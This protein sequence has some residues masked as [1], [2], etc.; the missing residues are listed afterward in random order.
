[1]RVFDANR[2]ATI[3]VYGTYN[4]PFWANIVEG[5]FDWTDF[6]PAYEEGLYDYS[7]ETVFYFGISTG[8]A[9]ADGFEGQVD[10]VRIVLNNGAVGAINFEP[11]PA[12][13]EDVYATDNCD[14]SVDV[15]FEQTIVPGDC[16]SNYTIYRTWTATDTCENSTSHTQVI[17]VIDTT[18]PTFNM[19]DSEITVSCGDEILIAAPVATDNC[20]I[21]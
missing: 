15:V 9:W 2:G 20:D 7:N 6:S 11:T 19:E 3:P 10:G 13:N 16:P 14:E 17:S 18:A 1:L 8:S 4:D 12:S 21:A 5:S